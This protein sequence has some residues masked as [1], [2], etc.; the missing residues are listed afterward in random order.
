M[1]VDGWCSPIDPPAV[2]GWT[3]WRPSRMYITSSTPTRRFYSEG[4]EGR[5]WRS[6]MVVGGRC[7]P[8]EKRHLPHPHYSRAVVGVWLKSIS[9]K[10][11]D[12]GWWVGCLS[13]HK[14]CHRTAFSL[15]EQLATNPWDMGCSCCLPMADVMGSN[16]LGNVR[17]C[18]CHL[19]ISSSS[20]SIL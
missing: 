2:M 18:L 12:I 19:I 11:A 17:C 8:K 14:L 6:L 16:V 4:W 3:H 13:Q 7:P 15:Q 10:T 5:G 9:P 1:D 20:F